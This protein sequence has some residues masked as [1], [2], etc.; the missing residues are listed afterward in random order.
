MVLYRQLSQPEGGDSAIWDYVAQCILRGQIPYRDVVEIKTPG[1]AYLSAFAMWLGTRLGV[2]DVMAV[3]LMQMVLVGLLSATTSLVALDYLR[4]RSAALIAFMIPLMSAY[5]VGWM[6]EGTQPKLSMTLFG[7]LAILLIAKDRPFWAGVCSMLSC[8]C[9][10]PGLLFTGTAVL[11]FS[12]YFTSWRDLRALKVITGAALPLVIVVLYFYFAGALKEFWTWTVAYN[13]NVYGPEE[14]K[15]LSDH[16]LHLRRVIWRVM[17]V[18]VI[19]FV[20]GLAGLLMFAV[21]RTGAK[22]KGREALQ[23]PVLFKDAL[24]IAPAVYVVFC[25][26]NLQSGP[27]LIPLF[28][29]IGI[30]AAWFLVK[31]GRF[32]RDSQF[33]SQTSVSGWGRESVVAITFVG[34]LACA[35]THKAP[36][37]TLHDQYSEYNTLA[38]ILSPED[39][40]YAVGAVEILVLLNRPNL[41]PYIMWDKGKDTYVAAER[42]GGSF[43][44]IINEIESQR[45]RLVALSRL[46]DV[47]GR[48]ELERWVAEHYDKLEGYGDSLY[49]RRPSTAL[50]FSLVPRILE[51]KHPCLGLTACAVWAAAAE[52]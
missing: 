18:K 22:L 43:K 16:L 42:Y 11:I 24:I 4:S 20:L 9:W 19:L 48:T 50:T 28:P 17:G 31:A 21:E 25:L 23:S 3:R 38:S 6:L 39:K 10:Q 52:S 12:R 2:R 13:Y 46:K 36:S 40:I 33:L 26:V 14:A 29:F 49:L 44:A 45:P 8:L 15:N 1:S 47:S 27:D 5:F 34:T 7:M 30:F 41:N 51:R 37:V 35:A 32:I